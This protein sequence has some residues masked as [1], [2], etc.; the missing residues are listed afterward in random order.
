N[1]F[2]SLG[3]IAGPVLAGFLFD[4]NIHFPYVIGA[5]VMMLGFV[6]CGRYLEKAPTMETAVSAHS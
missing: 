3:R 1:S 4:V 6:L 2:M 5:L